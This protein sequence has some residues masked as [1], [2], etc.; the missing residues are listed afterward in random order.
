M[1]LTVTTLVADPLQAKTGGVTLI[2]G[3]VGAG[4][5]VTT[6]GNGQPPLTPPELS[7]MYNVYVPGAK[8]ASFV[9]T[10][11]PLGPEKLY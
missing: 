6:I 9:A 1:L 7:R 11:G 2:V 10:H 3:G 4:S 5:M 8:K